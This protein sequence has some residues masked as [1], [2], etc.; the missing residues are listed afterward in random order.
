MKEGR[1]NIEAEKDETNRIG[2]GNMDDDDKAG[3][4]TKKVNNKDTITATTII[5][6]KEVT[7][8]KQQK[9]PVILVTMK[10]TK[11]SSNSIF[12]NFFVGTQPT[13]DI[14]IQTQINPGFYFNV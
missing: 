4:S 5:T 12:L 3:D 7:E 2:G 13:K 10:G 6:E 11:N 14:D 9:V 1:E 8:E